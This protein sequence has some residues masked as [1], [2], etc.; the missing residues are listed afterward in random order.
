MS[1]S[2]KKFLLKGNQN[3]PLYHLLPGISFL[4]TIFSIMK[5]VH[6]QACVRCTELGNSKLVHSLKLPISLELIFEQPIFCFLLL[7]KYFNFF[8]NYWQYH[9][10]FDAI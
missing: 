9:A 10:T 7:I 6:L 1:F 3:T 8:E 2:V 4:F 5:I